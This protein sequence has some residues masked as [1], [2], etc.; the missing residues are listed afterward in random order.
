MMAR[1]SKI[2]VGRDGLIFSSHDPFSR[3]S[4]LLGTIGGLV[5]SGRNA[6]ADD[7]L[8]SIQARARA[9]GMDRFDESESPGFRGIGDAP[10]SF[11]EG[12]LKVCEGVAADYRKHFAAKGFSLVEPLGRLIVVVLKGP[13]SYAAFAGEA[14]GDSDGGHYDL[15]DNWLVM[16]D[17]RGQGA[18]PKAPIAEVDNTFTLVHE[19][20]HLLTFNTGVLDREADV[21]LLVSEG[22]ATYGETWAPRRK[23]QIGSKNLR[24]RKGL[25][26]AK[27]EGARWIP[28]E[29]LLADDKAFGDEADASTQQLAYAESA[30]FASKMLHDK[31]W[32]PKFR[33][34]LKALREANDPTERREIAKAHLG[35]LARLDREVR[36]GR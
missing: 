4:W 19:T 15:K 2:S 18:N 9:A 20:F 32:L 17:F 24:R 3:R 10:A 33:D 29:T 25:A 27:G 13:Q 14:V 21:P 34:Y 26:L 22:L 36:T 16:F 6:G 12:A 11:R 23:G 1:K 35:D 5:F 7:A 8:G 31:G 28:L 30:L